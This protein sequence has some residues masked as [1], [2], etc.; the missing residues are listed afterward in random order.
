VQVWGVIPALHTPLMSVSNAIS[1]VVIL[2]GMLEVTGGVHAA[3]LL[4]GAV[5]AGVA[6]INCGG[7]NF[8]HCQLTNA[9]SVYHHIITI[10]THRSSAARQPTRVITLTSVPAKRVDVSINTRTVR[11]SEPC[12][13]CER[14]SVNVCSCYLGD[15]DRES[16]ITFERPRNTELSLLCTPRLLRHVS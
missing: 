7:T 3:S 12:S 2:G 9:E 6:A 15:R 5:A 14:S 8:R 10:H 13:A 16:P 11:L 4:I 1:G